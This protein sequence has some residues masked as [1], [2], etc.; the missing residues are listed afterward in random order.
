[1]GHDNLTPAFFAKEIVAGSLGGA[2]GVLV[3]HPMDLLKVNQQ[4]GKSSEP[5]LQLLLSIGRQGPLSLFKGVVPPL[6]NG[7]VYQSIMF[8]SYQLGLV[9]L[10][11]PK[12]RRETIWESTVAGTFAGLVSTLGTSPLEVVKI[13]LQLDPAAHAGTPGAT[14][15]QFLSLL[16]SG[17]LYRGWGAL[18]LRDGPGTGVYMCSYYQLKTLFEPHITKPQMV[19]FLAGGFAGVICWLSILPFDT[20][21]TRMQLDAGCGSPKYNYRG[22]FHGIKTIVQK[23]GV[24][25]LF[26]GWRPLCARAFPANAITFVVYE[27]VLKTLQKDQ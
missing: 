20:V 1:M 7:I 3:G 25:E 22:V 24:R 4:N 5:A 9:L 13:K 10:N 18:A 17:G 6:L 23:E 21:K 11:K 26:A 15:K 27:S 12:D 19:E 14:T 8:P 16:R 2:S